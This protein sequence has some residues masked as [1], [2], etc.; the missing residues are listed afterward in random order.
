MRWVMRKTPIRNNTK[1]AK[2]GT[3]STKF[4]KSI[5][6]KSFVPFFVYF[7]L[8]KKDNQKRHDSEEFLKDGRN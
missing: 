2:K 4:H 8:T 3:K 1:G 7:V 5:I 6:K